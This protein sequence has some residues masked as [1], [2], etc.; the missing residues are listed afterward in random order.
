LTNNDLTHRPR[1]KALQG[2]MTD[3]RH[4]LFA[5]HPT[6]GHTSALR[7]IGAELRRRGHSTSFAIVH[8]RV[9]WASA[10][11]EPIR[12]AAR[13][14][15]DI[16][17]EGAEVLALSASPASLWHAAR[18]PRA[19]G[20]AELEIALALFTSGMVTQAR[21][22]AGYV[23]NSNAAVVV[24]DYLMP[25]ALLGARLAQRPFVAVYHSA[26]PF[27]TDGAPPF[28]TLLPEDARG[29]EAWRVAEARLTGMSIAFDSRIARAAHRLGIKPPGDGVLLRPISP[30]LNVLATAPELEPGLL[31]LE[32]NVLMVGPCLPMGAA[33]DDAGQAVIDAL[34]RGRRVVYVSLGTVFNGQPSLFRVLIAGASA[35]GA[36][37]VVSA[38]ASF[39]ALADL[40]SPSVDIHR[41]VPQEPLLQRVDAVVTHGGNN[42]VQECL[43]AG[44]PMVVIPFG[45][46]Q[47]ANAHRVERLGVGVRMSA[48]DL[49]VDAVRA[50]VDRLGDAR[51]VDRANGL[52][53]A[54]TNYGGVHAAADAV[55]RCGFE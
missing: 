28:G 27:P 51:V 26:L 53:R 13:L 12:V 52:A 43:A 40:R 38:G 44:R 5:A 32:G 14:P 34:P 15:S 55:L 47:V 49:S 21:Q 25:T 33:L 23:R 1:P 24:G 2:N 46:D 39:D 20:Q 9:P 29:S 6:V 18:L 19:T 54:L 16:A 37:V 35:A 11:P 10:W 31:P 42:T 48:A 17:A 50:A 22:I 4:I 8:T 30:D 7:A 3:R 41:R 36:H 45:G